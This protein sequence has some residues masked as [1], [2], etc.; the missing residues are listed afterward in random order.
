MTLVHAPQ[1]S[2]RPSR[3]ERIFERCFEASMS[4]VAR[5]LSL[6]A[7]TTYQALLEDLKTPLAP[8]FEQEV[9]RRLDGGDLGGLTPARTLMPEVMMRFG[10]S[11]EVYD[12]AHELVVL[13]RRCNGCT[14][15]GQCWRALRHGAE[16]DEYRTLCPNA[17]AFEQKMTQ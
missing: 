8:A 6:E 11:P 5:E 12:D 17:G 9:A 14:V 15:A 3:W 7:S 1:S 16:V 2:S 10:L 13:E 4:R